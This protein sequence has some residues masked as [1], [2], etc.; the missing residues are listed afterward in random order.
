MK[1]LEKRKGKIADLKNRMD[2][3]QIDVKI[4]LANKS[5]GAGGSRDYLL[6]KQKGDDGE[7][8]VTRG[9]GNRE[10]IQQQK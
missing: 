2:D 9:Q 10:V 7:Y 6:N 5:G 8:E 1:E 3:L 4:T